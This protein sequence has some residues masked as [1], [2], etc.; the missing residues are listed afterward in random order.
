[1]WSYSLADILAQS[2][3][4]FISQNP[5]VSNSQSSTHPSLAHNLVVCA[6]SPHVAGD[7]FPLP[8]GFLSSLASALSSFQRSFL[9]RSAAAAHGSSLVPSLVALSSPLAHGGAV[10]LLAGCAQGLS[11]LDRAR[12]APSF[13]YLVGFVHRQLSEHHLVNVHGQLLPLS[14]IVAARLAAVVQISGCPR[15][16]P[17]ESSR[18]TQLGPSC[19]RCGCCRT[20]S[21]G[22]WPWHPSGSSSSCV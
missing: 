17:Q 8:V 13:T 12:L 2:T 11:D 7:A 10:E 19:L 22:L 21:R 15:P 20:E 14:L 9:F 3:L 5:S 18:T 16:L 4:C 1:M 6:I